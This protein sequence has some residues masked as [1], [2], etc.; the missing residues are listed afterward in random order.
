M[1]FRRRIA[2]PLLDLGIDQ[3][4]CP[5]ALQ[6]TTASGAVVIKGRNSWLRAWRVPL[7]TG[8]KA[9]GAIT[10]LTVRVFSLRW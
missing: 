2:E 10:V 5:V 3:R 1:Y 4:M 6:M 7:S 8:I 9:S